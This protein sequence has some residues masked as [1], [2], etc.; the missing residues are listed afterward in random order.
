[1]TLAIERDIKQKIKLN[2]ICLSCVFCKTLSGFSWKSPPFTWICVIR[3]SHWC[4]TVWHSSRSNCNFYEI[5]GRSYFSTTSLD[6]SKCL[7]RYRGSQW[8]VDPGLLL[9]ALECG[10]V[11][12]KEFHWPSIQM[13]VASN[14]TGTSAFRDHYHRSLSTA[15]YELNLSSKFYKCNMRSIWSTHVGKFSACFL[16]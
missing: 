13:R 7:S 1:M 14:W 2:L 5:F 9:D 6:H 4:L 11:F 3:W 16:A 8:R 10:T 12:N 15:F